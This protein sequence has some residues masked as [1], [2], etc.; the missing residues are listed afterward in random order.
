MTSEQMPRG[1][2]EPDDDVLANAAKL[3]AQQTRTLAVHIAQ[4]GDVQAQIEQYMKAATD[5]YTSSSCGAKTEPTAQRGP[6]MTAR[7]PQATK[8]EYTPSLPLPGPSGA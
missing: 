6:T 5:V 7:N 8:W 2:D 3:A 1:H 4:H